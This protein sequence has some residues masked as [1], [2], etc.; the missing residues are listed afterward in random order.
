MLVCSFSEAKAGP[1]S[2]AST[3]I[4]SAKVA[5]VE[6]GLVGRSASYSSYNNGTMTPSLGTPTLT[7]LATTLPR[8][9]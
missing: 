7:A 4:T 9:P 3:L 8:A 5:L 2:V 1:L 6:S